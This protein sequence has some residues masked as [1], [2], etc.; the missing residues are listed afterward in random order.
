MF[1]ARSSAPPATPTLRSLRFGRVF[2][3]LVFALALG[4]AAAALLGRPGAGDQ[5]ALA[6]ICAAAI[7]YLLGAAALY[8]RRDYILRLFGCWWPLVLARTDELGV[9]QRQRAFSFTFIVF[10][11]VFCVGAGMHI[12]ALMAQ[13]VLT[14][15]PG[16]GTGLLP[17]D[18]W[19]GVALLSVL[20]F[21]L[22]LTPQ[23]YLA[24]TLTPL[25]EEDPGL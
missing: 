15:A 18:P 1:P 19:D 25:P 22:T 8:A 10:M 6:L 5:I 14:D 17:T 4:G 24:W 12:G 16:P 21:A 20:L 2:T 7:V 23:A 9:R 11:S 3:A 13:T